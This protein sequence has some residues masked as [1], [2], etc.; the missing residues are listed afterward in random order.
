[1]ISMLSTFEQRAFDIEHFL[2]PANTQQTDDK[3]F[4]I[5]A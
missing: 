1:M 4:T 2:Q 3:I 5:L